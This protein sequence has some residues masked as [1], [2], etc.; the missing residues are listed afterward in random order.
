MTDEVA[1]ASAK[2][3]ASLIRR[4]KIGCVELLDLYLKRVARLNPKINAVVVLDDK[5]AR[6]RARKADRDAAKKDLF[7]L[8]SALGTTREGRLLLTL[9]FLRGE[10]LAHLLQ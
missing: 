10:A 8:L 9:S 3:L 5:R 1:F 6:E 7:Q 4:K 2:T